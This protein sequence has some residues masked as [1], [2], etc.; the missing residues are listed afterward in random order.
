MLKFIRRWLFDRKFP[1]AVTTDACHYCGKFFHNREDV[2]ILRDD[3]NIK[4]MIHA[5]VPCMWGMAQINRKTYRNVSSVPYLIA[6]NK[7][8]WVPEFERMGAVRH[9]IRAR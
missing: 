7:A 5:E 6:T 8:R 4:R 3:Q 9:V 2:L 1:P